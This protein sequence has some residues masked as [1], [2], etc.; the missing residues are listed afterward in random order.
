M[1]STPPG[2]WVYGH[3]AASFHHTNPALDGLEPGCLTIVRERHVN[4]AYVTI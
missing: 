4:G 2:H 3:N 1:P